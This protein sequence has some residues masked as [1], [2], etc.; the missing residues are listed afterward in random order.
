M[1][2]GLVMLQKRYDWEDL[3][4]QTEEVE[5]RCGRTLQLPHLFEA[6]N[7]YWFY[8]GICMHC[9]T[10]HHVELSDDTVICNLCG[11]V[12]SEGDCPVC[13]PDEDES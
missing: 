3:D 5:C 13:N 9:G 11:T 2:E 6:D 1:T 10:E 4:E 12:R 7:E 8:G